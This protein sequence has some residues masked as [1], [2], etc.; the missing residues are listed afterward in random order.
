[1]KQNNDNHIFQGLQ[2]DSATTQQQS[3]YLWDAQNIRITAR[4]GETLFTITNERGPLKIELDNII[5]SYLGHCVITDYLVLFTRDGS[6]KKDYIYRVDLNSHE[7]IPL[8]DSTYGN[9]DFDFDY[10][11]ETMPYFEN[12]LIQKVYWIDGKN[13]PRVINIID[14]DTVYIPT[15]FDF[16]PAVDLSTQVSI[17][18]YYTGGS[19]HSGVIQYAFTYFNKYMQE[20]NIFYTSKLFSLDFNDRGG[21]PEEI[22]PC[23]FKIN[24]SNIDLSFEYIRVYSI[25]RTS[26]NS[27]PT[28]KRVADVNIQH[29][30]RISVIDTGTIGDIIDFTE[31]LYKDRDAI[32][33][34]TMTQKNGTLFFGNIGFKIDNISTELAE[35]K[36]MINSSDTI[37]TAGIAPPKLNEY[38]S[39]KV[40]S[41]LE[42]VNAAILN[43]P[44]GK[45]IRSSD[46][47]GFKFNE[48]YRL[49]LQFQHT[50]GK[51]SQ[52]V[53]IGDYRNTVMSKYDGE[54]GL[55]QFTIKLADDSIAAPIQNLIEKQYKRVRLLMT[56]PTINDRTIIAQGVANPT[57][58]QASNINTIYNSWL[59]RPIQDFSFNNEKSSSQLNYITQ[60]SAHRI[61]CKDNY[62]VGDFSSIG[63]VVDGENSLISPG[64]YSIEIGL[65]SDFLITHKQFSIMSPEI[66]FDESL[67]TL[68]YDT[69][70]LSKLGWVTFDMDYGDISI[71]TSSSTISSAQGAVT[72]PLSVEGHSAL[73]SGYYY[74][75]FIVDDTVENN[76]TEYEKYYIQN[77]PVEWPVFMW[78][79][80]GSLNND[81]TRD[82]QSSVLKKKVISNYH[83]SNDTVLVDGTINSY[84]SKINVFY[85]DDLAIVK[86]D[87]Y[88][89]YGNTDTIVYSEG[90]EPKYYKDSSHTYYQQE[91][92]DRDIIEQT[93]GT[94]TV[95]GGIY[96]TVSNLEGNSWTDIS[97]SKYPVGDKTIELGRT[98]EGVRIKYK[99][100]PH[101]IA[102]NNENYEAIF[103]MRRT[104][105]EEVIN[106][107]PLIDITDTTTD[108][109]LY[110]GVS[111]DA[112]KA[113]KWIPISEPVLLNPT[114]TL[115]TSD[116]GDTWYQKY[117]CL[118]IYPYTTEDENQVV[119]IASFMCE[120]H[121][122]IDGRY[123]KNRGQW[124]NLN[125]SPS[126]FNLI[127]KV[128]SQLDNYFSYKILD[129]DFY[130]I[131]TF[132]NQ[133]TWSTQ[134]TSGETIDTWTKLTLASTYNAD[135]NKGD[136]VSL[137]TWRDIIYCFQQDGISQVLF[138][139]RVQIPTSDNIPIE[140]SN[141]YKVDGIRYIAENTGCVDKH[142]IANSSSGLYFIHSKSKSLCLL[143][144]TEIHDIATQKR[145][146]YWFGELN[147]N[148]WKLNDYTTR[149]FFDNNNNDL[150]IV[151]DKESLCYSE[152][153]SQF[154]S[155][156]SYDSLQGLF[157]SI[158]GFFCIRNN[159]KSTPILYSMNQGN[160]N[161]FFD[162][163]YPYCITF[164]SNG[165]DNGMSSLDKI[166]TNIEFKA[167]RWTDRIEGKPSTETINNKDYC[168][169]P[170][171][172]I[173]VWNE[174][175][176]TGEVQLDYKSKGNKDKITVNRHTN[177]KKKFNVWRIDIPRDKYTRRDRM[178]NQ[179][180][181]V[182]LGINQGVDN[183]DLMQLHNV[184]VIYYSI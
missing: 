113:N 135:G 5:G 122:N 103:S 123:D 76:V 89:Y 16:V 140:I 48:V 177:L 22:V 175:Q 37:T 75:D 21:S 83:N 15:S 46:N 17:D 167:D 118:R 9:L 73:I 88:K 87:D 171:D 77:T 23:S 36:P 150:Y 130:K 34:S 56:E 131:N 128:Y 182:T 145:M 10:P 154:V 29:L 99:S 183:T 134:K 2:R 58:Y 96:G 101:F 107:L 54:L 97:V 19:F 165:A 119:D 116:R 100:T 81:V 53:W 172:Y 126:N 164:I 93:E 163:L 111:S 108:K 28:C 64:K 72:K 143:S 156:M 174:Y 91:K 47:S 179:W 176:D 3:S 129:D 45:Y 71:Q 105:T 178:R 68:L 158:H 74:R 170:F 70:S 184:N 66:N 39:N 52:P 144:G 146:L 35:I 86:I 51:W 24:I 79:K 30:N 161:E 95:T 181:K 80:S 127:N 6:N 104:D 59:T 38:E 42:Q 162:N 62:K 141:N 92:I 67:Y 32:I 82:G 40:Y 20:S 33:A 133:I 155:F 12:N 94:Y 148:P 61:S 173:R 115:I 65:T 7:V 49:G 78:H 55:S 125:M 121:I 106:S 27:I 157:N 139:S 159:H 18:K 137:N 63:I 4:E 114:G 147:I 90:G 109:V 112:L 41:K 14:T 60:N 43:L 31:L 1:M 120:T 151:T 13:Q 117:E 44:T 132:P 50:T 102:S 124:S 85:Q 160:F 98:N 136:I 110:G 8:Y 57:V 84:S 26:L 25:L 138:N 149:L 168:K 166:F 11:I 153:L 69:Y 152:I 142:Q 180:I 169:A